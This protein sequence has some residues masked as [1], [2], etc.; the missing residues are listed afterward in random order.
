MSPKLVIGV[1]GPVGFGGSYLCVELLNRGHT[2]VGLS[3]SPERLG[4]H[5][6]YRTRILDVASA[7]IVEI[8][9]AFD[10][11]DVLVNEYGPHTAGENALQY[12]A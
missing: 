6:S 7:S 12:R 10:G 11:L 9:K 5:P 4:K 8:S 3:R 1:V 2:V